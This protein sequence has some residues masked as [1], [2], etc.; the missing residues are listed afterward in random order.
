[1][2]G[3][4]LILPLYVFYGWRFDRLLSEKTAQMAWTQQNV[5]FIEI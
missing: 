2:F 3:N 1:M 5:F 4:V